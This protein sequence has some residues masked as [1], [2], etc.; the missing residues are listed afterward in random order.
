MEQG[1]LREVIARHLNK[2][3]AGNSHLT[4]PRQ[5]TLD[6]L[7]CFVSF[8][9]LRARGEHWML[10]TLILGRS[11]TPSP[12]EP[13]YSVWGETDHVEGWVENQLDCWAQRIMISGWK[14][15]WQIVT[16]S[17]PQRLI[18]KPKFCNFFIKTWTTGQNA[19]FTSVLLTPNAGKQ[20]TYCRLEFRGTSTSRRKGQTKASCHI[21]QKKKK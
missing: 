4:L 21:E 3:V 12:T 7:D 8:T 17:I 13:L 10:C 14:F 20:F 19:F 18:L 2:K 15:N 6:Y 5:I 9:S 11:L 16:S 1:H